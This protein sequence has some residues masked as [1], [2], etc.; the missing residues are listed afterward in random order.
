MNQMQ[1]K[2]TLVY[3]ISDNAIGHIDHVVQRRD[4]L[5]EMTCLFEVD[6]DDSNSNYRQLQKKLY[7]LLHLGFRF[8][9]AL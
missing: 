3:Y 1:H 5:D 4:E 2:L 7:Y 9:C 8:G 6:C